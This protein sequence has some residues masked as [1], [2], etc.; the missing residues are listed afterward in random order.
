MPAKY[1]LL[2]FLVHFFN[3]Y[4]STSQPNVSERQLLYNTAFKKQEKDSEFLH[5]QG[6]DD[7]NII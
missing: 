3:I 6:H 1:F 7:I 4:Y 2:P 5:S